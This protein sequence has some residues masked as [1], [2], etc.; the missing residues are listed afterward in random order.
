MVEI[1]CIVCGKDNAEQYEACSYCGEMCCIDCLVDS[2]SG[3][4]CIK[5]NNETARQLNWDELDLTE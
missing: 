1:V 3:R 2:V 5:C 4:V